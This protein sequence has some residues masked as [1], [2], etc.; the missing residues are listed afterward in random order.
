M[1]ASWRA[2]RRRGATSLSC[3]CA[4]RPA[5]RC[6]RWQERY[7]VDILDGLGSTER[8]HTF[9]SNR[10]GE[11]K[12]G[13]TGKPDP[14]YDLRLVD[15]AGE[16]VRKGEIGELQVRGPTSALMYWNNRQL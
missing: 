7:G 6:R 14:G 4:S 9:L 5:R 12:Y 15:D 3:G 16:P 1:P 2:R 11:V 10:P 8:T 13:T